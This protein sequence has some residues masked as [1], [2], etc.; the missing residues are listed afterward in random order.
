M[1]NVFTCTQKVSVSDIGQDYLI[2]NK[3]LLRMLQEAANLASSQVGIGINNIK[4]TGITWLLLYW[5]LKVNKRVR[6][7]D[8][9]TIK[10]WAYFSKKIFSIRCFE[11]YLND[12]LLAYADSKWVLVDAV[13]HSI[14]K[15][16]DELINSYGNNT[17]SLFESELNDKIKLPELNATYNY[18][19]MKRDLDV[20][21]HVNNLS[22][23]DIATEALPDDVIGNSFSDVSII[24][25]K[26]INYKDNISCFYEKDNDTHTV[27]IFNNTTNTLS[28]AIHLK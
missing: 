27:Y 16:S 19:T 11:L 10:T 18:T 25:K 24:Y 26:E 5:R 17:K 3:G 4:E 15:I 7:N 21:H 13:K 23:L 1:E 12:E 8:T 22:F 9:V 2:T 14:L 20:N 28:G 6:Y